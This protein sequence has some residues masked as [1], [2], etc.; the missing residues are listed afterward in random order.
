[1]PYVTRE[2]G[3]RFV[4]PS[5]RDTISAK[6]AS[7]LK[8]EVLL[9]STSYGE[10]I[11]LQKK[12]AT[13]Y[14][15]AFSHD[16]GYLLGECVWSYFKRPIDMI[17]CEEIP[18]TSEAMLVIVKSGSVYLDGTFQV[19][20]IAEELVIFKTQKNSF[21]IYTYGNVPISDTPEDGKFS[22]DPSSVD[23]FENLSEPVFPTMPVVP[24]LQLQLVDTVL[25]TYGIGV[26][27]TKQIF[28]AVI[29]IA[30]LYAAY[31]YITTSST[32]LPT[33]FAVV[34]PSNPYQGYFD[35]LASPDPS[36]Q[37]VEI[38]KAIYQL[39]TALGW[40]PDA[41][42][43]IPGTPGKLRALM[44]SDGARTNTLVDWAKK[45]DA[46][47]EILPDGVYVTLF[48]VTSKR[49]QPTSI[50]SMQAL[51]STML[52]RMSYIM[53]GNTMQFTPV[54]DK[55][56]YKETTMTFALS[57][58]APM[59][60]EAI[61]QYIDGLPLVLTKLTLHVDNGNMTGVLIFK[62]LGN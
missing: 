37:I 55:R 39:H 53:P 1:M 62:A 59:T 27:P 50:Y 41:V 8:K 56:A 12:S 9:L 14:E 25:K 60:L 29:G 21:A 16:T 6:K 51:I 52:D 2:D 33:T 26:L 30:F 44:I 34:A 36:K 40:H 20:S 24:A 7:L 35:Q 45:Y 61:G 58:A 54:L 22:F 3:E 13:Q 31:D 23:S 4:I 10:Y 49:S 43:Y 5:Y 57:D 32:Q 17:Y 18:N 47:I 15:V 48:V 38:V 11:T 28:L 42:E 19:D 46:D